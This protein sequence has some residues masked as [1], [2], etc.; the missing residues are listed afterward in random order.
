MDR[1][2]D[3]HE[4]PA[5]MDR[6]SLPAVSAADCEQVTGQQQVS[7][8]PTD[9]N[10]SCSEV[11]SGSKLVTLREDD[12]DEKLH[13]PNGESLTVASS[14]KVAVLPSSDLSAGGYVAGSTAIAA[15]TDLPHADA[16]VEATLHSPDSLTNIVS[17]SS[18]TSRSSSVL[19]L[20]PVAH[21]EMLGSSQNKPI[22]TENVCVGNSE[23]A[24]VTAVLEQEKL[25]NDVDGV[26]LEPSERAVLSSSAT[27]V[28]VCDQPCLNDKP[29]SE[30]HQ[31]HDAGNHPTLM[32]V[33]LDTEHSTSAV[34]Q[35]SK[36]VVGSAMAADVDEVRADDV[37]LLL[38]A[39]DSAT[40]V[41]GSL[42]SNVD[43]MT[44]ALEFSCSAG[45]SMEL[46]S[47]KMDSGPACQQADSHAK[48]NM[49]SSSQVTNSQPS[50]STLLPHSSNS[51]VSLVSGSGG[52]A[53]ISRLPD[54]TDVSFTNALKQDDGSVACKSDSTLMSTIPAVMHDVGKDI[55]MPVDE[56]PVTVVPTSTSD[57]LAASRDVLLPDESD[58]GNRPCVVHDRIAT[59]STDE[60]NSATE[61]GNLND[62]A[63]CSK[64]N[65]LASLNSNQL[66]ES[67]LQSKNIRVSGPDASSVQA[68][69]TCVTSVK[70]DSDNICFSLTS[71]GVMLSDKLGDEPCSLDKAEQCENT[72]SRSLLTVPSDADI[73]STA[74]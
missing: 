40:S 14:N 74:S 60:E 25:S 56:P 7:G 68:D 1:F 8:F 20:C 30:S 65:E 42:Y 58:N 45:V 4:S 39:V 29:L 35:E 71:G 2:L 67:C 36:A 70:T 49:Q 41:A 64:E 16:T 72:D 26:V 12:G 33:S 61:L 10:K 52:S 5:T 13:I 22:E 69:G 53:S 19:P 18:E 59:V 11:Q 38:A 37:E 27:T 23:S 34:L 15:R 17:S 24:V 9:D 28:T 3:E 48:S 44:A 46:L 54:Y 32:S 47:N 50:E 43:P 63:H 31:R 6:V 21:V 57:L 66:T 51:L 55:E 62:N 73:A